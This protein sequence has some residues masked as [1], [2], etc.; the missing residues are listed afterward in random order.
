MLASYLLTWARSSTLVIAGF[1]NA[2]P[3]TSTILGLA[4]YIGRRATSAGEHDIR[5]H[6]CII[7]NRISEFH[8]PACQQKLLDFLS[9]L[10]VFV[11]ICICACRCNL[12]PR[13]GVYREKSFSDRGFRIATSVPLSF[14]LGTG[15]VKTG[16]RWWVGN[17]T[18]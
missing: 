5:R 9:D 3:V 11:R 7:R 6:C 8:H 10:S 14:R 15:A 18:C 17:G 12:S 16:R 1:S 2:P 13:E 4:V